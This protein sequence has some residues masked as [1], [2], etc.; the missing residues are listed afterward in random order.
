M[1][2]HVVWAKD[3]G[4]VLASLR[5]EYSLIAIGMVPDGSST[6]PARAETHSELVSE[7]KQKT[8][9][10]V[11][12]FF[13]LEVGQQRTAK[14]SGKQVH[15]TPSSSSSISQKC[16]ARDFLALKKMHPSVFQISNAKDLSYQMLWYSSSINGSFVLYTVPVQSQPVL[17]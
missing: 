8:R 13:H 10:L 14:A 4:G 5:G 2:V 16:K 1:Y 9:L 6:V 15:P 17:Q 12:T 3:V 7:N 11:G